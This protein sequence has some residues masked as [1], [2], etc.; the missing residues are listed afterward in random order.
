MLFF[1]KRSCPH[2]CIQYFLWVQRSLNHVLQPQPT[3]D[4]I[5]DK[6]GVPWFGWASKYNDKR[7]GTPK[8]SE[9]QLVVCV[10]STTAMLDWKYLHFCMGSMMALF[11]YNSARTYLP[12]ILLAVV[13]ISKH[14]NRRIRVRTCQIQMLVYRIGTP[15]IEF[16]IRSLSIC[17]IVVSYTLD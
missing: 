17:L 9:Y 11:D 15:H 6:S 5:V 7:E 14:L 8:H 4:N 10:S 2:P 12:H 16:R 1:P 13:T 3:R